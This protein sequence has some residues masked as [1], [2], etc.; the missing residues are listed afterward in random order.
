[1]SPRPEGD[2]VTSSSTHS[3]RHRSIGPALVATG[4]R[5][6]T[7]TTHS[8]AGLG[9]R[10]GAL[11]YRDFRLLLFGQG[12]SAVG[13]WMQM[14]AQGWLVY[15][16]T[17]S[18][19]YLGLVSLARA[20]PVFTFTLVGG[21]VADRY[22]RK[23]IVTLMNA[24]V[25]LLAF[26][27]GALT[28]SGMITVWHVIV[29]AFLMGT[30]F[31]F[32]MPARQ[33]LVSEIVDSKDVVNAV[34]LNSVAFNAA[35]IIGPA[36]AAILIVQIGEGGV[37]LL[38]GTT[39]LA[40]VLGTVL[41]RP[42]P[43]RPRGNGGILSNVVEGLRYVRRTPELFALVLLGSL[44]SLLARPYIQ[45]LPAF[46]AD[47]L[48]VG[49]SGL[50]ALN[51][52][53]GAG[54]LVGAVLVAAFGSYRRRGWALMFSFIGFGVGL[55]AFAMS[56]SFAV[57]LGVAVALGFVSAYSGISSNTVLQTRSGARMRGRVMSLHGLTM[58][59][60]VPLGVM[61]EGALG[62]LFGVPYVVAI[63]G[64]LA[65]LAAVA[66]MVLVPRLRNLE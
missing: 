66:A 8:R 26:A 53:T 20:I 15:S 43:A 2:T 44:V 24:V 45:L 7:E 48:D 28:L 25:A 35:Q 23:T 31:S 61:L 34:G 64:A 55:V 1:V 29:I 30:A 38:N 11:A 47:V 32:E 51:A 5:P 17:G 9:G 27:L 52:A 65:A 3:A 63:G 59:G 56:G 19:F 62:S 22:D 57:S 58:M 60:I 21:A 6:V 54:A 4:Q 10:L 50:G 13:S 40:V 33:S 41:M 14:V 12:V 18:P 39:Y 46:A 49:A 16:L 37:F 36:L 42:I